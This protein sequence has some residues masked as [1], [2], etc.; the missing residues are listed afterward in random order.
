[1]IKNSVLRRLIK[2]VKI[3]NAGAKINQNIFNQEAEFDV[4]LNSAE[5][6]NK[7]ME[8]NRETAENV[9]FS[10]KYQLYGFIAISGWIFSKFGFSELVFGVLSCC[11]LLI[12]SDNINGSDIMQVCGYFSVNQNWQENLNN[13][14]QKITRFVMCSFL[15]VLGRILYDFILF[16]NEL[17][18]DYEANNQFINVFIKDIFILVLV[19]IFALTGICYITAFPL[20]Y[21]TFLC[22]QRRVQ[23]LSILGILALVASIFSTANGIKILLI[24]GFSGIFFQAPISVLMGEKRI[25]DVES[26]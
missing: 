18:F 4:F 23:L 19:L 1:M 22:N 3:E 25:V 12:P 13:K 2:K 16:I 7:G 14:Q 6:Q 8:T 20:Q 15:L 17:I 9:Y 26:T 5:Q 21:F 24:F 10:L 11:V